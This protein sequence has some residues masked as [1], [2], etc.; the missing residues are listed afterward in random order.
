[1][2]TVRAGDHADQ[3]RNI[4][5]IPVT[6]S[7]DEDIVNE[8]SFGDIDIPRRGN[9][10]HGV[11]TTAGW[12]LD[13]EG[14]TTVTILVDGFEQGFAALAK[15]RPEVTFFYPGYPE[16]ALPGWEFQLDTRGF[17]NGQHFLEALVT[18]DVGARTLI[19]RRRFVIN[20]P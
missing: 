19:G 13:F 1:V 16:S 15:S 20:N 12:A 9:L 7:C 5:E 18:D 11:V 8:N 4:A 14:I 6:F 10:Y 17:S 2:L 3:V